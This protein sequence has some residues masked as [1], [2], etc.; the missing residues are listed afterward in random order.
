MV[1]VKPLREIKKRYVESCLFAFLRG[2]K[3]LNW[4]VGVIRGS[5]IRKK[6]LQDILSVFQQTYATNPLFRHL[7]DKYM[8]LG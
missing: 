6:D 8:Q 7:E 4:I 2:K 3:N 5:E 1:R